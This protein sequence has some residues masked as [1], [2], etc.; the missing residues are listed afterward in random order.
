[1]RLVRTVRVTNPEGV[2]ARPADLI[3]KLA[4]QF[5]S[6]VSLTKGSL[7]IDAKSILSILTLVAEQGCELVIEADGPDAQEALD[8]LAQLFAN[9]FD[10][11]DKPQPD[12]T[13]PR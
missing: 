9:N 1:M 13:A 11:P 3:A 5:Q 6:Q 2:H 4:N 12:P 7:K 10:D 8:R